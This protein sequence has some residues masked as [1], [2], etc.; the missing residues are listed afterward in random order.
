[1]KKFLAIMATL[2]LL[3]GIFISPTLADTLRIDGGKVDTFKR[4]TV[5]TIRGDSTN[6]IYL[7][8]DADGTVDAEVLT[9]GG[10]S[11]AGAS[12]LG[13]INQT[14][15][16]TTSGNIVASSGDITIGGDDIFMATNTTGAVLVGDGTNYNPVLMDTGASIAADGAVT[17]LVNADL[18]GDVV[19]SGNATTLTEWVTGNS[20]YVPISGDIETAI[21]A[22]T[23]G[24]TIVLAAGTYTIDNVITI[25]QKINIVGQGIGETML[26]FT[27]TSGD[28]V[29]INAE[30]RFANMSITHSVTRTGDGQIF[31]ASADCWFENIEITNTATG[32]YYCP[33][34]KDDGVITMNIRN[35]RQVASGGGTYKYFINTGAASTFNIYNCQATV[36]D[37][38]LA[39]AGNVLIRCG[40][41]S[42]VVNVYGG[43]YASATNLTGG[44]VRISNG[45]L[46]SYGATFDGSGATGFDVKHEGGTVTLYDTTLV[47]N[48]TSGTITYGGTV[49]SDNLRIQSIGGNTLYVGTDMPYTTIGAAMTAADVYIAAGGAGTYATVLVTEGTYAEAVTFGSDNITLKSIGGKETTTITQAAADVV[50]FG[51]MSGCTVEG[52]TISVTAADAAGDNC[53]TG[54][55]DAA[56]DYNYIKNCDITWSDDGNAAYTSTSVISLSDG[57]WDFQHCLINYTGAYSGADANLV[58]IINKNTTAGILKLTN[59]DIIGNNAGTNAS[60]HIYALIASD[61][62]PVDIRDCT[63]DIDTAG[64]EPRGIYCANTGTF[65]VYTTQVTAD[66]SASADAICLKTNTSGG[67]INSYGCTYDATSVSANE[68]WS[69]TASSTTIN[70]YHDTVLDGSINESGTTNTYLQVYEG[71]TVYSSEDLTT[72]LGGVAASLLTDVTI[73]AT[74]TGGGVEATNVSLAAGVK[75]QVKIFTFKTETDAGDT[76]IIT[77]A[78]PVGFATVTFDAVGDTVTM[79]C[80]GVSWMLVSNNNA[81]IG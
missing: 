20:V 21:A 61:A 42:A 33:T 53:I 5:D 68:Y 4:I 55:N 74:D 50:I 13:D 66:C 2:C 80:D 30:T 6:G 62:T 29:D 46:N 36:A 60:S 77:P 58:N 14:G 7:D 52:F 48:T 54:S 32:A 3:C 44:I 35:C 63:F 75:G 38:T 56:S 37:C 73:C 59:C 70:S 69:E 17:V 34:F 19:S 81:T 45:A 40:T 39:N 78:S 22:A 8:S 15:D 71:A 47:N 1:M 65:N 10:Y 11:T 27:N 67:V 51:V 79:V 64:G 31:V 26:D 16:Y 49:A 12:Q 25:S 18:T 72:T 9:A 23:A 28:C 43:K 76:V 57:N 24:D 41:A